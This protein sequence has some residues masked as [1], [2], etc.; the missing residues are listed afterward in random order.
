MCESF[1]GFNFILFEGVAGKIISI[2]G[3]VVE[4]PT[5]ENLQQYLIVATAEEGPSSPKKYLLTW[6]HIRAVNAQHPYLVNFLRF[7]FILSKNRRN[8]LDCF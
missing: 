7:R 8:T 6:H 4:T 1:I 5:G 2:A 3:F